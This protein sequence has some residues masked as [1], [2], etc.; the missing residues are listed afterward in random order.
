[1]FLPIY[2]KLFNMIL[3]TGFMPNVWLEDTIYAI[4]KNKRDSG[5]PNNYRPITIL[6]CFGKFFTF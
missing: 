3:D 5:D 6:S 4:H 1:M 2:V